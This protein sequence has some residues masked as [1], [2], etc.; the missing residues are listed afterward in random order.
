MV[1]ISPKILVK[2]VDNYDNTTIDKYAEQ[3]YLLLLFQ[4]ILFLIYNKRF[5]ITASR[6]SIIL[7]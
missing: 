1:I 6:S 5:Y 2:L 4:E 7:Q 3:D